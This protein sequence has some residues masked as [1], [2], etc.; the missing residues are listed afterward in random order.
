MPDWATG[1]TDVSVSIAFVDKQILTNAQMNLSVSGWIYGAQKKPVPRGSVSVADTNPVI[2]YLYSA[3][4]GV[5]WTE[6][7]RLPRSG[8]GY[9]VPGAYQAKMTYTGDGYMGTK[10]AAFTVEKRTLTVEK[11]TL[12]AENKN[13][14]GTLTAALKEGGAPTLTGV[15]T[16]TRLR[17][18][19]RC[20]RSLPRQAR[21]RTLR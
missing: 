18:A 12:E 2:T 3:D 4:S 21:K 13:Y 9:I 14:D 16:G 20:V 17:L 6:A 10:T 5:S 8:S 15:L 1:Q 11:G 19:E 7:E